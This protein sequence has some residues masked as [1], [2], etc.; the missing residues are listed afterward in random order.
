VH[1]ERKISALKVSNQYTLCSDE[2][3]VGRWEVKGVELGDWQW[4]V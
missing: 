3:K 2:D 1:R 4:T